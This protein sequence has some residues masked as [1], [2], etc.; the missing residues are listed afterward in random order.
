[1]SKRRYELQHP[2]LNRAVEDLVERAQEIYGESQAADHVREIL[3]SGVRLMRDGADSGDLKLLNSAL[4]ELRHALRVF[5]PYAHQRKAAI[6]GSARTQPGSP[7]WKQLVADLKWEA[8]FRQKA[9]STSIG[10][11]ANV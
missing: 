8:S 1:M 4:K 9:E 3:V 10:F 11:L 6:F 7:D 2:E 5:A